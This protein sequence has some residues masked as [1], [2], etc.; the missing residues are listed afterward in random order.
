MAISPFASIATA[1]DCLR[2]IDTCSVESATA[3]TTEGNNK[4][5]SRRGSAMLTRL[6][7]KGTPK[8]PLLS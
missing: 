4:Q 8:L 1:L 5:A 7:S 6:D 3:A 2:T